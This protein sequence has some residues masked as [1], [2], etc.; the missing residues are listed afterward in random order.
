MKNKPILVVPGDTESIF[1]EIFLKSLKKI[2]I[3]NP[4]I[5]ISSIKMVKL[6][7]KKFK[8]K[9]KIRLIDS[10]INKFRL[11]NKKIN[12]I[13]INYTKNKNKQNQ[14]KNENKYLLKSFDTAFKMIKKNL[15]NKFL[16]G[17]IN[18]KK[19]L[20]RKYPGVT[21]YISNYFNEKKTGMLIYNKNLS[22][23][24]LTTHLPIKLVQKKITKKLIQDKLRI[25]N[26]FYLKKFNFKPIIGVTGLNPHCETTLFFNEDDKIISPAI[27]F[28]KKNGINVYGPFSADTIFLKQN[29]KKFDV[30]LG[31]YH[32]QVLAPLKTIYE[33]DAINI[34]MGLPFLR[35]SPDHG[36]N[37][38]MINKN[39]SN[40]KSLIRALEFLDKN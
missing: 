30:I 17:P 24:P 35:V 18:K 33:Y 9:K 21:E 23:C 31:M 12:V 25:I 11:D 26:N 10:N 15:T 1:F 7:F 28:S 36:P 19:F 8:I 14:I 39:L 40:P 37:E 27:K 16:N 20:N 4:I 3:K 38:K 32:D 13:N 34:T 5:L 29:R 22:V 2:K 6:N